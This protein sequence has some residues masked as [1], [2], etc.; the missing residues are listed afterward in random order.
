MPGVNRL[1]RFWNSPGPEPMPI[2]AAI[3]TLQP[4]RH[5]PV[6]AR[7]VSTVMDGSL[8]GC[9]ALSIAVEIK[10]VSL[11]PHFSLIAVQPPPPVASASPA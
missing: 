5:S 6:P 9:P 7:A 8:E 10:T 11:Q 4:L 2:I 3:T 1:D